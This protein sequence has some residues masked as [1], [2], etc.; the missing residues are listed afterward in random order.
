MTGNTE[1]RS[2]SASHDLQL[3]IAGFN[4]SDLFDAVKL[5]ELAQTF[6]SE[7]ATA[8]PV[9]HDALV[10]YIEARGHGYEPKVE[11][12]ILTDSAPFLSDFVAR[13]FHID[14]ERDELGRE[15]LTQ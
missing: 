4:Y 5:K 15:I 14:R 2:S 1:F 7:V 10:K 8:E 11:S 9:L 12:K 6:Y 13:L 3:G